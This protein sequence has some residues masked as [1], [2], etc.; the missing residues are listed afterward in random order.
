MPT[1]FLFYLER[2]VVPNM[3]L[4]VSMCLTAK[5]AS[6]GGHWLCN[7]QRHMNLSEML[8]LQGMAPGSFIQTCSDA[9]FGHL[10][11]NSMSINVMERILNVKTMVPIS[12]LLFLYIWR[13]RKM[14]TVYGFWIHAEPYYE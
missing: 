2:P 12:F 14:C 4:D 8:R 1:H 13:L 9:Q 7:R 6:E 5:R 3:M 10:L 11:G